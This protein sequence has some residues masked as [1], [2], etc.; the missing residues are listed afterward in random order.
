MSHLIME[1]K[2]FYKQQIQIEIEQEILDAFTVR[3]VIKDIP[4]KKLILTLAEWILGIAVQS[5]RKTYYLDLINTFTE[6]RSNTL[7]QIIYN[8]LQKGNSVGDISI[9]EEEEEGK[10]ETATYLIRI[11]NLEKE[12][13]HLT[14]ELVEV[15]ESKLD[16]F[17]KNMNLEDNIKQLEQ[18][19][20]EQNYMMDM[21]KQR[22]NTLNDNQ[23]ESMNL[24]IQV[25]ELKGKLKVT[26]SM[27]SKA[28]E[29]KELMNGEY[30]E[31]ILKLNKEIEGLQEKGIKY[32]HLIN[33]M[34]KE[35]LSFNSFH[36][37]KLKLSKAEM[38]I[39]DHEDKIRQLR[40]F[41]QDKSKYLKK[42]E[43]LNAALIQES[44]KIEDVE[45]I[46]KNY[47][48]TIGDYE[49]ELNTLKSQ[50]MNFK[51]NENQHEDV[52]RHDDEVANNEVSISGG[53]GLDEVIA[54]SKNE[55]KRELELKMNEQKNKIIEELKNKLKNEEEANAQL[56]KSNAIYKSTINE[57]QSKIEENNSSEK[58]KIMIEMEE[59]KKRVEELEKELNEKE[60]MC[61]N[62]LDIMSSFFHSFAINIW[63]ENLMNSSK[64]LHTV[65][66]MNSNSYRTNY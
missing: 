47:V 21:Y 6:V 40:N 48:S 9:Q 64:N 44:Q 34:E 22:E 66:S 65:S 49:S 25:S 28:R 5:E 36:A 37:L 24:H 62:E 12:N 23:E 19:V 7:V 27:L 32:D 43:D 53:K 45:K 63:E 8:V 14:E 56:K 60:E 30:K 59:Y 15:K 38:T 4:D 57:F 35:K 41:D 10:E 42:I 18:T 16:L 50:F 20:Q 11:N 3:D 51:S 33:K 26:E 29:E 46:N 55:E 52:L 58:E 17:K 39:K 13:A 2:F 31:K 61:G 1:I 54:V